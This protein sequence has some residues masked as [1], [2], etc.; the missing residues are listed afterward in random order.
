L[1]IAAIGIEIA[2]SESDDGIAGAKH[3]PIGQ[4]E[5]GLRIRP[6]GMD[7]D[8]VMADR[9]ALPQSARILRVLP[10]GRRIGEVER[11]QRHQLGGIAHPDAPPLGFGHG[12]GRIKIEIG[13]GGIVEI[14]AVSNQRHARHRILGEEHAAPADM[15]E[16]RV[17]PVVPMQTR[18]LLRN[19]LASAHMVF[20][21]SERRMRRRRF[22]HGISDLPDPRAIRFRLLRHQ[23]DLA[24]FGDE[25]LDQVRELTRS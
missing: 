16:D 9:D 24:A 4:H 22:A 2:G 3:A 23:R 1:R 13:A 10:A 12:E 7:V 14:L 6:A 25:A 17:R 21:R 20:G 15:A 19:R 18:Q 5:R 11:L 8:A